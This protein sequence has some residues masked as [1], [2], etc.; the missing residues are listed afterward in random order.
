MEEHQQRARR[1]RPRRD[2]EQRLQAG[3][4]GQH[5]HAG[6]QWRVRHGRR[7]PRVRATVSRATR[8]DHDSDRL[9][10]Q[11]DVL[12]GALEVQRLQR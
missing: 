9:A 3:T 11:R 5:V 10:R 2:G 7:R 12:V 4:D 6:R 1:R 8:T